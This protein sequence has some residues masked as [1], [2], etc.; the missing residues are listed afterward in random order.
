M[1]LFGAVVERTMLSR[2][3]K[4]DPLYGL[5]FTFGLAL[6]IEGTFLFLRR[7]GQAYAPPSATGGRG[8]P[9]FMFL[10]IYRGWVVIASLAV[11]IAVW[12][13]IEKTKIGAYLRAATENPVLVQGLRRQR[14]AVADCDLCAARAGAFA[15]VLA[16]PVY[17]VS[18]LMGSNLIIIVFAV[19]VVGGMA[20]A[21]SS[22]A[23]CWA[24]VEGWPRSFTP[25]LEHRDLRHHGDRS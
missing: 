9:G 17:Q 7:L 10:P 22:P 3:Y 23:T 20:W 8:E 6:T 13:L 15:G 16:A 1:G 19:V 18:P 21:P 12:L 2:L 4:L 24:A 11:C 5:L 25:G 14:A